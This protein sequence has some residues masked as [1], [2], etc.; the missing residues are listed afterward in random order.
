MSEIKPSYEINR[1]LLGE[2][3]PLDAPLSIILDVSERCNFKCS[4]CFRSGKKDETWGY[5]AKN[6]IMPMALFEMV[7]KQITEFPHR[8]KSISLSG[9]GEPLCNPHLAEMAQLL[10]E[11][12]ATESI[13]I[14][15]N[16][17]LLTESTVQKITKAGFSRIVVS[18]QGLDAD[19]YERVCGVKI[20]W[21]RFYHNLE[22]LYK[23]KNSQLNIHIK[24][25]NVAFN[26]GDRVKE[27]ER[28]YSLFNPIADSVYI[29]KAVPLWKNIDV[30]TNVMENK[31]GFDVGEV[32]YCPIVFYKMFIAPDG[33]IYPCTQLPPPMSLGNIHIT[34]LID[35]WNSSERYSFLEDHLQMTRRGCVS[36]KDCFVPINTVM[37]EEDNID[38]YR[39][40]I[41]DRMKRSS[42]N[43]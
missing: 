39:D 36:C 34:S 27:E 21:E 20:I 25:S 13:E 8:P 29:E 9:H 22:L 17:S 28:F 12:H 32:N 15:T 3:L 10:K 4:Y 18:L 1:I 37:S 38:P 14:H 5:A 6:E 43:E 19:G 7:V 31:F 24:I 2:Q 30:N 33:E 40:S 42:Y 35:A 26:Q 41:L 11:S 23:N 16:A